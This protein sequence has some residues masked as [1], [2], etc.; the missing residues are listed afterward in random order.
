MFLSCQ[1]LVHWLI[2]HGM[3]HI[4]LIFMFYI[5]CPSSEIWTYLTVK[6]VSYFIE[7][8]TPVIK[9]F[10]KFEEA[11]NTFLYLLEVFSISPVLLRRH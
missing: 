6:H 7:L 2:S 9:F 3:F 1:D 11:K 5:S 8:K 10:N 4:K